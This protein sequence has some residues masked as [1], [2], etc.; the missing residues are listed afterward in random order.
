MTLISRHWQFNARSLKPTLIWTHSDYLLMLPGGI[1]LWTDLSV[2]CTKVYYMPSFFHIK[3]QR[4]VMDHLPGQNKCKYK[5]QRRKCSLF[6]TVNNVEDSAA[7]AAIH[8]GQFPVESLWILVTCE[9][10]PPRNWEWDNADA[11]AKYVQK[12]FTICRMNQ[13]IVRQLQT[14]YF[15]MAFFLLLANYEV[16]KVRGASSIIVP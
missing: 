4:S 1:C 6:S 14:Y 12:C 15:L 16:K 5:T 3:D 2:Y 9:L 13:W 8:F 11:L 7:A 10:C